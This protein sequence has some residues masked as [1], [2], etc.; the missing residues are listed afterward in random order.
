MPYNEKLADRI[1]KK[2]SSFSPIE[3]KKMMG[4]LC[5]MYN[6]KMCVGIFNTSELM[7][8]IDPEKVNDALKKPGTR[9]MEMNG[10][11]MKG[12]ILVNETAIAQAKD[13]NYWIDLCVAFNPKA[14]AAKK[15][16]K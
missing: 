3:E 15:Q 16:N 4:G 2:L 14:K 8:R 11:V 1:R 9:Q 10:R 6:H 5:F 12:Y 7:C 13:F